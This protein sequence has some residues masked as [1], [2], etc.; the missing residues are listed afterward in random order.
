VNLREVV[1]GENKLQLIF[2]FVDCDLKR[3]ME[4]VVLPE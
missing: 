4:G 2:D 1:S 3:Y